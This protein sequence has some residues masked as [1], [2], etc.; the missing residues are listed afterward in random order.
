MSI[1]KFRRILNIAGSRRIEN[2]AQQNVLHCNLNLVTLS[3]VTIFQLTT[4]DLV[5]LCDLVTVFAET[6]CVTKSRL[7]STSILVMGSVIGQF[8]FNAKGFY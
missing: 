2:I 1:S 5:T 6:K 4:L 8:P 3:L 7:H